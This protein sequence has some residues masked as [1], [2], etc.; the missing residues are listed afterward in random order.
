MN[1]TY[2]LHK[3]KYVYKL[4]RMFVFIATCKCFKYVPE[5]VY[6]CTDVSH[7]FSCMIFADDIIGGS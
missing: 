3:H 7:V 4:C 1:S 5:Y 6:F 2:R